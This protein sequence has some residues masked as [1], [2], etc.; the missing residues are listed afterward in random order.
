MASRPS[1]VTRKGVLGFALSLVSGILIILN[2]AALL[3]PSFYGPPVNWS[4]IFFWMPSLGPSYAFA[5]GFI[6]GLVLIFGAII[7]I[8][9]HGALADVVIFPFAIFSLIIGGGFVAGMILG[10]VGGIIG[11]L[12]R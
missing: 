11:A 8:L 2:S 10:I 12:K 5:I 9:G 7:M 6:I 1:R 4:S 3:A